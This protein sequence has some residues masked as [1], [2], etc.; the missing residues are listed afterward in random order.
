[1][2]FRNLTPFSAMAY[3]ME[4][5]H[6]KRHHVVAMKTGFRLV[7]GDNG[8]WQPVLMEYP[9]LPLCLEDKFFGELNTSPVRQE[10]D[11]VPLKPACDILVNGTAYTPD[12]AAVPEM[13]AGVLIHAPSGDMILDKSVRIT[14]Q[15]FYRQQALTG[16]WYETEPAPF[17]SLPLNYR[18]AF[19][20]ECR[21]AADCEYAARIPEAHRLTEPQRSAHPDSDNPPLAHTVCPVNPLGLGYAPPW[22]LRAGKAQQVEAPRI[23]AT[24]T[25]FTLAHFIAVSGD[26]NADWSAPEY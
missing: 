17:T 25:P 14:G 4:D 19:G 15:R 22:Y 6:G 18:Y 9:A 5:I 12:G 1:M 7:P 24:D 3:V 23:I 10:S 11:L 13:T 8:Q 21:M 2:E 26:D 16:Q 20:G